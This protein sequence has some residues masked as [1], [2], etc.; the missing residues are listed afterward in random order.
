MTKIQFTTKNNYI[1]K[2]EITG[3]TG[4][5]HSGKDVL[6]AG[7]SA[8]SQSV[9]MGIKRVVE[10]PCKFERE[11][12]RGYLCLTIMTEDSDILDKTQILLQTALISFEDLEKQNKKYMKVEVSDEIY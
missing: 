3:H 1:V 5:A 6:C 9:V 7:I 10:C 8:I 12:G 11:D 4:Y 2:M